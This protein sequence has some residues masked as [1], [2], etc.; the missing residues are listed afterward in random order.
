MVSSPQA[1]A[2]K[3][4]NTYNGSHGKL[5]PCT[6]EQWRRIEPL[7]RSAMA[8]LSTASEKVV[9]QVAT[10][11]VRLSVFALERHIEL[12]V[13][14]ILQQ[15]FIE[16]FLATVQVG[17][18]DARGALRKLAAAHG[19]DVVDSPLGYTKRGAQEPYTDDEIDALLFCGSSLSTV[20]RQISFNALVLLGAGAG[21]ARNALRDVSADSFHRHGE[22]LFVQS[23][24]RCSLLLPRFLGLSAE[25]SLARPA[26]WLLGGHNS[27]NITDRIVSWSVGKA[28]IPVLQPD[29]LRSTYITTLM[30]SGAS[31]AD[32]LSWTGVGDLSSLS[33]Y[34]A[35]TTSSVEACDRLNPGLVEVAQ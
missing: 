4:I 17:A 21:L 14:L 16:A 35:Y 26:G 20:E 22:Q 34:L 12:D 2:V 7:F 32:I 23:A 19:L 10:P 9:R 25:L 18:P 3:L 30:N 31:L 28:G 8:P 6:E 15:S 11:L 24:E 29:R 27:R 5:G 1:P 33:P 13:G